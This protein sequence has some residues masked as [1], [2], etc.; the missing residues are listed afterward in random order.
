MDTNLKYPWQQVVLDAFM[1][2]R[3]RFLPGKINA[4]ERTIA[5]RLADPQQLE[6]DERLALCDALHSLRSLHTIFPPRAVDE[7]FQIT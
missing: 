6:L 5:A 3:P 7:V 1:E 2:M 4:A